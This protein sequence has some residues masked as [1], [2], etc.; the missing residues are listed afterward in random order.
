MGQF[1]DRYR[2]VARIEAGVTH[3]KTG[4]EGV[5]AW[6]GGRWRVAW[7]WAQLQLRPHPDTC[8]ASSEHGDQRM[9]GGGDGDGGCVPE[10]LREK[11]DPVQVRPS[12]PLAGRVS[13]HI[14]SSLTCDDQ[15]W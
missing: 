7:V 14:N 15:L 3:V 13:A 4:A 1:A 8:P 2:I 6:G 5:S 12:A 11:A 9:D 10:A